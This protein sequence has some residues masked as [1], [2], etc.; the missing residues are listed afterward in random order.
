MNKMYLNVIHR[1]DPGEAVLE[2]LKFQQEEAHRV[3]FKTTILVSFR[4]LFDQKVVNYV[5]E[6]NKIYGDEIGIHFHELMCE[7]LMDAAESKEPALYLH[8]RSSK[9]KIIIR[10]F[11]EFRAKFGFIPSAVGGYILDAALLK[12]IKGKYPKVTTA[13]TNCFE[14]GVK[15]YEGNN[16]SWHLFSDGGPWG[17]YYA[18]KANFLCPAKDEEDFVGI[19]GLPHLNRDMILAITSRDDYFASHP[20]NVVRAKA[21]VGGDSPYMRRFIDQWIEQAQHNGYSY[22]SLFVSSPWLNPG[23]IFV[24][25]WEDARK[26]YTNSLEFLSKRAA[27]GLVEAVT[28]S[29][30]GKWYSDNIKIGKQEVTLWKDILCGTKRQMFWYAD[31]SMRATFDLNAGGSI[32]DLRPYAGQVERDLG[33]DTE[34]LWNGNYPFIIATEHRPGSFH[35]CKISCG[36]KAA[37]VNDKR[38]KCSTI[39]NKQKGSVVVTLEPLKFTLGEVKVVLQTVFTLKAQGEVEI[40]R[41]LLEVSDPIVNV[42]I[43]EYFRGCHGTT[44]YPENLKGIELTAASEKEQVRLAYNYGSKIVEVKEA[45]FVKAQIPQVNAAVELCSCEV[46]EVGGFEEGFLF[47]PYF[48]MFLRSTIFEGGSSKSCLKIMSL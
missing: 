24:D 39:E 44:Q 30:F 17:P 20:V 46:T 25:S 45:Q 33:P 21:N 11:E 14:E 18:S 36:D 3:G 48:S 4:A 31:S 42:T 5:K 15:M 28:I 16:R 47:Q 12:I 22:Y 19:V 43:E 41:K 7:E 35:T 27:E 32:C 34:A 23:N 26:L 6:Q 9:E 10:F 38:A 40:E 13:I 8:T 29:E 2:A 37:W 1:A